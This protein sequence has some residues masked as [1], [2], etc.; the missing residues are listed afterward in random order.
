VSN[1][2][3][4]AVAAIIPVYNGARYLTDAIASVKAQTVPVT[5]LL[6][7]D[8]GSTDGS[9]EIA[10]AAGAACL[11]TENGGPSRARN[12]GVAATASPLL[13]FLDYDDIWMPEKIERQWAV[14]SASPDLG[15]V[16]SKARIWLEEGAPWPPGMG[17]HEPGGLLPGALGSTLMVRRPVFEALGGFESA[18]D[19]SEDFEWQLRAREGGF[20]G[21]E[22]EEPLIEYRVHGTNASYARDKQMSL[23]LDALKDSVARR[24]GAT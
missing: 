17:A 16:S 4:A 22:I 7:V 3:S 6:V 24:R 18:F 20:L 8:D 23:T 12:A 5:E 11:R 19:S 14:L 1:S 10:E 21:H 2:D 15:F 9:G 13:A